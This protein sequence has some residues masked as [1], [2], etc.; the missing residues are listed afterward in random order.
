METRKQRRIKRK[1]LRRVG[2]AF[3]IVSALGMSGAVAGTAYGIHDPNVPAGDCANPDSQ[4]VGHPA[5][6]KANT[7][8]SNGI[9][10]DL[11]IDNNT[12]CSFNRP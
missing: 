10:A 11:N 9:L 6:G 4:A 2:V 8:F 3:A 7:A 1:R 5:T 12:H